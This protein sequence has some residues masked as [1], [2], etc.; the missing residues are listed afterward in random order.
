M[1]PSQNIQLNSIFLRMQLMWLLCKAAWH[2]MSATE[3]I[4]INSHFPFCVCV[5]KKYK[6]NYDIQQKLYLYYYYKF[7]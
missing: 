1:M 7:Q 6:H 3:V 5:V 2:Q 4:Q